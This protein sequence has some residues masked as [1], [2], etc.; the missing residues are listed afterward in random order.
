[1]DLWFQELIIIHDY[2]KDF[3]SHCETLSIGNKTSK[4]R[5]LLLLS[6]AQKKHANLAQ[7]F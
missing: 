7:R 2:N 6:E 1:M 5:D 4:G 3:K